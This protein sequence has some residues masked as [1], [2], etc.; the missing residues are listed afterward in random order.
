MASMLP[1]A[2]CDRLAE[3]LTEANIATLKHLSQQGMGEN[4]LRALASEFGYLEACVRSE[5]QEIAFQD[6][7]IHYIRQSR[8]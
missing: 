8:P 4:T 1:M 5:I 7:L 2:R 3:L 6:G